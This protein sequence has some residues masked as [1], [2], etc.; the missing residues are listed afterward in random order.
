[1]VFYTYTAT[2]RVMGRL[3][4][5]GK[6]DSLL[7]ACVFKFVVVFCVV[8][9]CLDLLPFA[10]TLETASSTCWRSGKTWSD[11]A[12]GGMSPEMVRPDVVGFCWIVADE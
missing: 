6:G 3:G 10:R 9:C 12:A 7:V 11:K 8:L 2:L 1:M 4:K 5:R